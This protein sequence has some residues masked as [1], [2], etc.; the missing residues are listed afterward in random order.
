MKEFK[1]EISQSF[2]VSDGGTLT[3]EVEGA[4]IQVDTQT[5][6]TVTVNAKLDAGT[7]NESKAQKI[8]DNYKID[9]SHTGDNVTAKAK[10]IGGKKYF[11]PGEKLDVRFSAAVPEKYNLVLKSDGASISIDNIEGDVKIKTSGGS[12]STGK[13]QG[14]IKAKTSGGSIS[15]NEVTGTIDAV[16]SGGSVS[17]CISKQPKSNCTLKTT[18][19]SITVT[20]AK[21]IKADLEAKTLDGGIYVDFPTVKDPIDSLKL[22]TKIN[23]GGPKLVLDTSSGNIKIKEI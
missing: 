21:E 13:V 23:G 4:A 22:S 17:V 7:T 10:W 15:V 2:N 20:L 9:F 14:E 8:F 11:S 1:N 12:I 5:V 6:E 19:G 18:G 16:T 3:M